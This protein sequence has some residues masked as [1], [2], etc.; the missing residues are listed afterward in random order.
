MKY[1]T[2][3][4]ILSIL[5]FSVLFIGCQNLKP[6]KTIIAISKGA[7]SE[8]YDRYKQW[9]ESFDKDI[10]C[11][12]LTYCENDSIR[13]VI[14]SKASGLLLTGGPDVHPGRYGKEYDTARCYIEP[15]R[16]TLE[17][18]LLNIAIQQEMPVLG[19]C[20]GLQLLNVAFGGTLFVDIPED[21]GTQIIHRNEKQGFCYQ[22][23]NL[24]KNSMLYS[25][26]K[27]DNFTVNSFH[28][29]GI[30]KLADEFIANAFADDG[31]IE[32]IERKDS[33]KP[34]ILAVQWHPEREE[35]Q[36][37]SKRI[38]TEF[39]IKS[40]EYSLSNLK[41]KHKVINTQ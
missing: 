34:F 29:Q 5:I 18:K 40:K 12:D 19:I 25:L 21:Y 11:I 35:F 13:A 22:E 37:S 32:G 6:E 14:M 2:T 9:L 17:Y 28:H 1:F 41:Q 3:F 33:G 8:H 20:R 39:I 4:F 30:E 38:A 24:V 7:G 23:I 31:F 27:K 36:G 16:D 26:I 15:T 10:D